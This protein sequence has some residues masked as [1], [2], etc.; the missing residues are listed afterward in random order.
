LNVFPHLKRCA[1]RGGIAFLIE[2]PPVLLLL[3]LL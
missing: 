3:L 2:V 1:Y